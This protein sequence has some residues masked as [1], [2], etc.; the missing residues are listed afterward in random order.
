[1]LL[2]HLPG[3]GDQRRDG[4]V[5]DRLAELGMKLNGEVGTSCPASRAIERV[6]II[7]GYPFFL[8]RPCW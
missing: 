1:M 3:G 4:E 5:T 2:E 6:P 7:S 8:A